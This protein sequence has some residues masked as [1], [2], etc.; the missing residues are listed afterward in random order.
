M[1]ALR[2]PGQRDGTARAGAQLDDHR[3][4]ATPRSASSDSRMS[5]GRSRWSSAVVQRSNAILKTAKP[6]SAVRLASGSSTPRLRRVSARAAAQPA[7]HAVER[8]NRPAAL[9]PLPGKRYRL[10]RKEARGKLRTRRSILVLSARLA[11][12]GPGAC[13]PRNA[14]TGAVDVD[15]WRGGSSWL[16]DVVRA[17]AL[18]EPAVLVSDSPLPQ[19]G[20]LGVDVARTSPLC[21]GMR[22]AAGLEHAL[23]GDLVVSAWTRRGRVPLL[24]RGRLSAGGWRTRSRSFGHAPTT[25]A[26]A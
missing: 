14:G 9:W 8:P 24:V 18:V 1:S 4:A 11:G 15:E 13:S 25:G 16:S 10:A 7:D 22:A 23:G 26:R 6:A 5:V 12:A 17:G 21:G 3:P 2:F 20:S 19:A